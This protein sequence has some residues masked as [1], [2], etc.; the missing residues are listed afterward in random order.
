MNETAR[1]TCLLVTGTEEELIE[2]LIN[3]GNL[4]CDGMIQP[5]V[6]VEHDGIQYIL[7]RPYSGNVFIYKPCNSMIKN[8]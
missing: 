1:Y 4:D 2:V 3:Q 6:L 7:V 8:V 5:D